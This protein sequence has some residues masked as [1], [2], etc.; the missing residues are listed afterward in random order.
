MKILKKPTKGKVAKVLAKPILS[1]EP[2]ASV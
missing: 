1:S 2:A